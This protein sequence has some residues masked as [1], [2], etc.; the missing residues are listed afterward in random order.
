MGDAGSWHSLPKGSSLRGL[1]EKNTE[2]G[3]DRTKITKS[4]YLN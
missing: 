3:C 2:T 1:S 4:C